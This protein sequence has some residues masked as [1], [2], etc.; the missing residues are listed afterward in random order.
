REGVAGGPS[1][2]DSGGIRS[3]PTTVPEPLRMARGHEVG[4]GDRLQLP[5]R[6]RILGRN[7]RA[8]GGK[9]PGEG[10]GGRLLRHGLG[11][12]ARMW[13]GVQAPAAR[14]VTSSVLHRLT[15]R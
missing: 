1:G 14:P 6:F 9:A 4:S 5:T 10:G 7:R 11:A 15:L 12:Q 13:G 2:E 8:D 3:G